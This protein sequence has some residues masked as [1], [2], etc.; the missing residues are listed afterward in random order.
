MSDDVGLS[1][2]LGDQ[3]DI[4]RSKL[5]IVPE[6]RT[7][8][9]PKL[10]ELGKAFLRHLFADL[11][12]VERYQ[13][14]MRYLGRRI[15]LEQLKQD[16]PIVLQLLHSTYPV[17]SEV[18]QHLAGLSAS[19]GAGLRDD[20]QDT[21]ATPGVDPHGEGA[22]LDAEFSA[23]D[24]AP[25]E[26][27]FTLY[28]EIA[29]SPI[30]W[31][32]MIWFE[33]DAALTYLQM[34]IH[35]GLA[36]AAGIGRPPPQPRP[37]KAR[38][39]DPTDEE[40]PAGE[41]IERILDGKGRHKLVRVLR[42]LLEEAAAH[43]EPRQTTAWKLHLLSVQAIADR[44]RSAPNK[45]NATAFVLRKLFPD[46]AWDSMNLPES[47]RLRLRRATLREVA[48]LRDW[49]E[50]AIERDVWPPATKAHWPRHGTALATLLGEHAQQLS[51]AQRRQNLT[52]AL[53]KRPLEL[54]DLPRNAL[55]WMAFVH[56]RRATHPET[57]EV[58]VL[59][60]QGPPEWAADP[61]YA[62]KFRDARKNFDTAISRMDKHMRGVFDTIIGDPVAA[63][64]GL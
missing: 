37:T 33:W 15:L 4:V 45:R 27:L 64:R 34:I 32:K 44:L 29:E 21:E 43:P 38:S 39:A 28:C 61:R 30:T 53:S 14:L 11:E 36:S 52:D 46:Y 19:F 7:P 16:G 22:H 23:P 57:A 6:R 49:L 56:Q 60:L 63:L 35:N 31:G 3:A 20:S 62:D 2:W 18:A 55:D 54:L 9:D 24:F 40:L 59:V 48:P 41:A 26:E 12:S 50:G 1:Q 47:G 8:G 5:N 17:S 42:V 25:V 10:A 13:V 58:W 51:E